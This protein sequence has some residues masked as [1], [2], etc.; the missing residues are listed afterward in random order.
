MLFASGVC[1]SHYRAAL[2]QLLLHLLGRQV[3]IDREVRR[4]ELADTDAFDLVVVLHT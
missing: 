2:F 1:A 4:Q 3:H